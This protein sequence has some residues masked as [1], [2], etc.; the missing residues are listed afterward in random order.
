MLNTRNGDTT[1]RLRRSNGSKTTV[2]RVVV[3]FAVHFRGARA[4]KSA[5]PPAK[6][7]QL[8]VARFWLLAG[9]VG[10]FLVA[11]C[12]FL[13]GATGACKQQLTNDK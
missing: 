2:E 9:A 8:L 11:S 4:L 10:R 12:W 13:D 1:R 3:A 7:G 6:L 5:H